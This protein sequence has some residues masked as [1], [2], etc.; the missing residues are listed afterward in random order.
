M[1][2][3]SAISPDKFNNVILKLANQIKPGGIVFF[4]DYGRY[5]M[6][7]LRFAKRG[8]QKL[9]ENLYVCADKTRRYYF[10]IEEVAQMFE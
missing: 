9:G 8:N 3:L 2:V 1:F 10:T 4:R 6:G 5:D 7:Q